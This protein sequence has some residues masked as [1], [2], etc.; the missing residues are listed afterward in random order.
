MS[1]KHVVKPASELMATDDFNK[2]LLAAREQ[3]GSMYAL[4]T[5][6]TIASY[7]HCFA[8]DQ[9]SE[10]MQNL[11]REMIDIHKDFPIASVME[12]FENA[13]YS[14]TSWKISE[15]ADG[16]VVVER[17]AEHY[18]KVE[19]GTEDPMELLRTK[20]LKGFKTKR[21]RRGAGGSKN[22]AVSDQYTIETK[23]I[24]KALTALHKLD[25]ENK[26]VETILAEL[27]TLGTNLVA[28]EKRVVDLKAL[29][30]KIAP[31]ASEEEAS[32]AA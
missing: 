32:V 1:S 19:E 16:K 25:P 10:L 4:F 15:D 13:T 30:S 29:G 20:G 11:Y 26:L 9:A 12:C 24:G 7:E 18:K 2:L 21:S 8:H 27:K 17:D 3:V 5:R 22:G 6:L 31:D 23:K 28:E 14:C